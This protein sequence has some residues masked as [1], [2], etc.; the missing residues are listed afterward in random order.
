MSSLKKTIKFVSGNK[1][2]LRELNA[3]LG[4]HFEVDR[5]LSL[6]GIVFFSDR[7]GRHWTA[8]T[9]GGTRRDHAK[10]MCAC[11]HCDRRNFTSHRW[12]HLPVLQRA[13]RT[14][15]SLCIVTNFV[16]SRNCKVMDSDKMVPREI[17]AGGVASTS[18]QV[19]LICSKEIPRLIQILIGTIPTL[20][21]RRIF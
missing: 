1:N 14:P 9:S 11:C 10:K 2:K 17:E 8:R 12:G 5:N 13:W 18:W 21:E 6:Y 16:Q 3:L 19:L 7:I 4:E 20:C 15:G